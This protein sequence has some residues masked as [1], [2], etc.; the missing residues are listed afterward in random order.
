MQLNLMYERKLD[1]TLLILLPIYD[2]IKYANGNF[3]NNFV[4]NTKIFF[5]IEQLFYK[6]VKNSKLNQFQKL[7]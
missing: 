5:L 1:R 3:T 2:L 6:I 7:K 4:S